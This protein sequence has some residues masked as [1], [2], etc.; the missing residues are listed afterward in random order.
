[1]E[2]LAGFIVNRAP[3]CAIGGGAV[4][5]GLGRG[6][7]D[8][9]VDTDLGGLLPRGVADPQRMADVHR[10]L[11]GALVFYV[12]V[13]TGRPDGVKDP[14]VLRKIAAPAGVPRLDRT[15]STRPSRWRI[16]SRC[17]TAR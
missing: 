14:A 12:V 7:R 15:R 4:R 1:M 8:L 5:R 11:A 3:P 16:T 10:S 17:C 6:W 2:R 13:D 9:R